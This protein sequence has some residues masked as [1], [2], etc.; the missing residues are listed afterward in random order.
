[1]YETWLRDNL[2]TEGLM[3]PEDLMLYTDIS[4]AVRDLKAGR[5]DLVVLDWQ[6]AKDFAAQGGVK[7]VEHGNYRQLF[8]IA[9]PAGPAHY[10]INSTRPWTSFR[11]KGS[12]RSWCRST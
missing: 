12:W 4:Q 2:V 10:R 1:M 7:I 8:A 9:V 5:L 6:P 3:E 11:I